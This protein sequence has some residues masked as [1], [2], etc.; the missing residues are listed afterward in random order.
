M[1]KS[2]LVSSGP[3]ELTRMDNYSQN[4]TILKL[5][6]KSGNICIKWE[7]NEG[8]I[9]IILRY[10]KICYVSNNYINNICTILIV[11]LLGTLYTSHVILMMM[12]IIS[13]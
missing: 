3:W 12:S 5:I 8:P 6:V 1:I 13:I 9:I 7:N 4:D 10:L 2:W 11:L